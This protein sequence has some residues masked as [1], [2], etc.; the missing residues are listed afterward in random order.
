M[1]GLQESVTRV[2]AVTLSY[3]GLERVVRSNRT[4]TNDLFFFIFWILVAVVSFL[5]PAIPQCSSIFAICVC[6]CVLIKMGSLV[7]IV[8]GVR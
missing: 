8:G 7:L 5:S 4:A 3:S 1:R 6:A 2:K